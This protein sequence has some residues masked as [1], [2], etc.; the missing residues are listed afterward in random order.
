MSPNLTIHV[1]GEQVPLDGQHQDEG[2]EGVPS[3]LWGQSHCHQGISSII[4]L[5]VTPVGFHQTGPTAAPLQQY[6]QLCGTFFRSDISI[7]FK[8]FI[9]VFIFRYLCCSLDNT[10]TYKSNVFY[11]SSGPNLTEVSMSIKPRFLLIF[12]KLC[13]M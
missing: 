8:I 4:S 13:S 10:I 6:S 1:A 3:W 5:A 7:I 2:K 11:Y 9:F 12:I